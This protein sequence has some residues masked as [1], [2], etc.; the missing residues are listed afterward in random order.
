MYWNSCADQHY[1]VC[2][3]NFLVLGMPSMQIPVGISAF[4]FR[5]L[6]VCSPY[7][8]SWSFFKIITLDLCHRQW[9]NSFQE[10][11][12]DHGR[13]ARVQ[14][15]ERKRMPTGQWVKILKG[16]W[17]TQGKPAIHLSKRLSS[18]IKDWK[19]WQSFQY[20]FVSTKS[21][22]KQTKQLT[23]FFLTDIRT[24]NCL[25]DPQQL[26]ACSLQHLSQRLFLIWQFTL[27]LEML[28]SLTK[29]Q[30][31]PTHINK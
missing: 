6:I 9:A 1:A 21:C 2:T 31:M 29:L 13:E 19:P 23:S 11:A 28:E 14:N 4:F 12:R 24:S 26:S 8:V 18:W 30:L 27:Q 7:G 15:T 3:W 25:H 20:Y 16:T 5:S 10:Q 22:L 17:W